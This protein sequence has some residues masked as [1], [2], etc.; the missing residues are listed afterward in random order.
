MAR[1][2]HVHAITVIAMSPTKVAI[3]TDLDYRRVILPAILSGELGPVIRIGHR[4]R[5]LISDVEAWLR[6]FPHN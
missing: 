2:N 5:L 6:K 1:T 3:A 4:R